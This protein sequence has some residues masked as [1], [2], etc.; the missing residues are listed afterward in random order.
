VYLYPR[1]PRV[2][3]QQ[4]AET[5]VGETILELREKW[6]ARHPRAFFTPVGAAKVSEQH[7]MDLRGA[8]VDAAVALGFPNKLSQPTEI[9]C[10]WA[11]ILRSQLQ[12]IEGE[13]GRRGLWAFLTCVLLPDLIRWR[14]P[15][16]K[17]ER[18]VDGR[19]NALGR[20]WQISRSLDG[21]DSKALMRNL[22]SIDQDIWQ[23]L[24]E[25][26]SLAGCHRTTYALA[27]A[28]L[29]AY[30]DHPTLRPARRWF[31]EIQKRMLRLS[32]LVSFEALTHQRLSG[33]VAEVV[34]VSA[35]ALESDTSGR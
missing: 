27:N 31:R 35:G 15:D 6:F 2:V 8:M 24:I 11:G 7:L 21:D 18:Y 16:A 23:Q 34:A 3:A 28:F 12:I 17:E 19:R 29:T 30:P 26:P 4:L 10:R 13:T 32:S 5:A 20:L 9:D 22:G 25:R 1:L 14:W 33:L